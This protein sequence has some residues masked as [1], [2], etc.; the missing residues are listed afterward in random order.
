[1][2]RSN[3]DRVQLLLEYYP[4][5][6]GWSTPEFFDDSL[7]IQNY[8]I[9]RA[10]WHSQNGLHGEVV[11]GSA[12][13]LSDSPLERAYF[14]LL[15]RVS[16]LEMEKEK[17]RQW[18][19]ESW[20]GGWMGSLSSEK[21]FPKSPMPQLWEYSRSHGVAL[22]KSKEK[23]SCAALY[24][25]IERD[26]MLRSWY[27]ALKPELLSCSVPSLLSAFSGD[28]YFEIY[29]FGIL[30]GIEVIGVFGF[31]THGNR[32]WVYGA[33]AGK[34]RA[35]ALE[36][37]ARECLQ[38][39]AFLWDETAC[40]ED[41]ALELCRPTAEYHQEVYL[42]ASSVPKIKNWL[43]RGHGQFAQVVNRSL[44]EQNVGW[45]NITPR[46]LEG[47]L[48]VIKAICS[49]LTPL[50]FGFDFLNAPLGFPKD[51]QPHPLV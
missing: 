51:L 17:S 44:R 11:T 27:G 19:L 9:K 5:P 50:V 31:S 2:I 10:G 34:D 15:E 32:P 24:E 45:I 25:L 18:P 43:N 39:T 47:K 1:M 4:L 14:E 33:G 23:A 12:V 3:C 8:Q 28:Y 30:M 26:L 36:H 20:D 16:V 38:R 21:I 40:V 22:H 49:D 41:S 7:V 46:W 13:E 35:F 48:V 42:R 6:E 29:S 37:A